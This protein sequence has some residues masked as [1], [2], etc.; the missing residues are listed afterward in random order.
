[1][2]N[3]VS[4]QIS[5]NE[6]PVLESGLNR[7]KINWSQSVGFKIPFKY[8]DVVGE[9]E[10]IQYNKKEQKII[11]KYNDRIFWNKPIDTGSFSNCRVGYYVNKKTDEF[12]YQ[13]NN[14]IQDN[15]RNIVVLKME[16]RTNKKGNKSKWYKYRCNKCGYEGWI[17]EYSLSSGRGCSCCAGKTVIPE[18]NSIWATARWMCDLGVSE[19][20]AKKYAP[21][22]NKKIEVICPNCGNKMYKT[23]SCIY[24]YKSIGCNCGDGFSYPEKFMFN[25]LKQL[26]IDFITEYSPSY[27]NTKR[28]DFYIPSLNLVI[29]TDGEIGHKGGKL[30]SKSAKSLENMIEI[31]KW[32]DKQHSLNGVRTIRINC[33]KSNVDYIKQNIINSEL[34]Q[35]LNL[36]KIEWLKA[37]LYAIK[38]NKVKEVCEYWNRKKEYET[39]RN[40]EK[41]F[42][43]SNT[44]VVRYLK[45]GTTHG[46]CYY[47]SKEEMRKSSRKTGQKSGKKVE[48]LKNGISLGIFESCAEISR[49]SEQLL[50]VK[51][52]VSGISNV[53]NGRVN[54]YKGFVF[55]YR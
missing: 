33:F 14:L 6:L 24:L 50:G 19:E 51:L 41:V 22:S 52:L 31:D 43:L 13:V 47:D 8:D 37:D 4:K 18:I 45:Q 20:D 23:I 27:L 39:T 12:K 34:N 53:C 38:S 30:Y 1:M 26:N 10:I 54:S 40:L 11:I 48:I 32:K 16:Y 28:S 3:R 49:Q 42:N 35:V 55:I 17:I 2:K 44:T 15:K 46:W 5:L 29:E 25:V 21:N 36:S 9:F 7:G